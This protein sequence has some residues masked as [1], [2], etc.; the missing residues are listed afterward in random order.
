MDAIIGSVRSLLVQA[1]GIVGSSNFV[2]AYSGNARERFNG[3]ISHQRFIAFEI[4]VRQAE[5]RPLAVR[6]DVK[7]LSRICDAWLRKAVA[8]SW[9]AWL[10]R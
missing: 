9:T 7:E 10:L 5:G 1:V 4:P 8:G 3:L 2:P 6:Q